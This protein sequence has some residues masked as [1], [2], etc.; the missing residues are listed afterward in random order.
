[1]LWVHGNFTLKRG[2]VGSGQSPET[3][4]QLDLLFHLF[5]ILLF[6]TMYIVKKGKSPSCFYLTRMPCGNGRR[7]SALKSETGGGDATTVLRFSYQLMRSSAMGQLSRHYKHYGPHDI[8][9]GRS[10]LNIFSVFLKGSE[11]TLY[12]TTVVNG[13]KR[14]KKGK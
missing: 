14:Q 6:I 13:S 3:H 4:Q 12:I 2:K 1:M 11:A 10:R 7:R 9:T 8:F 5:I